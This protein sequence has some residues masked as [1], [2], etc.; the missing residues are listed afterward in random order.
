MCDAWKKGGFLNN[1]FLE[2]GPEK[3]TKGPYATVAASSREKVG[4][5]MLVSE[6]VNKWLVG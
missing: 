2:K 4:V 6:W 1:M 3:E 5:P